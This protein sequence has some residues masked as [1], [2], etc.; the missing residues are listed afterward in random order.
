MQGTPR[1]GQLSKRSF[2]ERV[3]R[4]YYILGYNQQEISEQLNVGRSSVARFLQEARDQGV[5][6]FRISSDF[7][8]WRCESLESE[9]VGA[10]GLKD[11]V[12]LRSDER[13]GFSFEALASSYLNSV[14]PD[15]GSVGLGWGRTLYAV[16]THMHSCDARPDLKLIQLSGG[17]G[18]KEEL[19]PATSVVQQWSRALHGKALLLPAPAIVSAMESKVRFLDD[20]SV[21][22]IMEETKRVNAAIVGIGHIGSDATIISANLAADLHPELM[23]SGLAGDIAFHFFDRNGVFSAYERLSERV[24]GITPEDFLNIELRI[25]IAHGLQKVQAIRGALLGGLIGILITTEET[26]KHLLPAIRNA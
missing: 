17:L 25:G 24:I 1:K 19:V 13:A 3:A 22:E 4:M 6:Q 15:R 5:V 7:E 9:L 12:V 8:S 10:A 16:G 23:S 18:A 21:R 20:P 2:L 11:C 26:A 14:L